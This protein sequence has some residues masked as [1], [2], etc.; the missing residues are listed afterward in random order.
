MS[1]LPW[2]AQSAARVEQLLAADRLPHAL[3]IRAPEG[4]GEVH[5]AD[6]LAH[7]LLELPFPAV[8]GNDAD[9]ETAAERSLNVAGRTLAHGDLR[10]VEPDGAVIKVDDIRMLAEFA[11]GTRRSAPRKVAVV[12]RAHL[13]NPSAANALLKTLEEPPPHTHLLLAT[14]QP[15]R[16]LPT[17]VSRCQALVIGA[18]ES[19]AREWLQQR[20][21]SSAVDARLFEYGNAPLSCDTALR[22]G[23]ESLLPILAGM[24]SADQPTAAVDGLLALD[25]DRLLARWY[26]YCIA[27]A[28]GQIKEPWAQ[29]VSSRRMT[30]FVDEL[31]RTRRQ[32]LYSNSANARLLLERLSVSWRSMCATSHYSR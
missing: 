27:L 28:A 12:E 23:E 30:G 7:R 11:I 24:A 21:E 31:V 16:L 26:R 6:W 32:L 2:Q 3:L 10:W 4:W 1:L 25:P 8:E 5:F 13:M 15:G 22:E 20:W 18:D 9:E 14:A 19:L 29:G 17:I